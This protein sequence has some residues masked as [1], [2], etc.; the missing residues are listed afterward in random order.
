[1][2]VYHLKLWHNVHTR[3]ERETS[4]KELPAAREPTQLFLFFF[5]DS[6]QAVATS[7]HVI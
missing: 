3:G 1:M 4:T 5:S 2:D 7:S 6:F